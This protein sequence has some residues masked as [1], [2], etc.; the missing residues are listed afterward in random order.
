MLIFHLL[1]LEKVYVIA[2]LIYAVYFVVETQHL[3]RLSLHS[4]DQRF[5]CLL[6]L[7]VIYFPINYLFIRNT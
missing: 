5:Y 7:L 2:L 6:K 1:K 4:K 3:Q